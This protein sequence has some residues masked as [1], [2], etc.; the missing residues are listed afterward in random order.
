MAQLNNRFKRFWIEPD[1]LTGDLTDYPVVIDTRL[2]PDLKKYLS[3]SAAE[4]DFGVEPN[5]GGLPY[6]IEFDLKTNNLGR[7]MVIWVKLP[8]ISSTERTYFYMFYGNQSAVGNQ[9]LSQLWQTAYPFDAVYHG[10]VTPP[11]PNYALIDSSSN[12]RNALMNAGSCAPAPYTDAGIGDESGIFADL[13]WDLHASG[14]FM[15]D[16]KYTTGFTI[17]YWASF[18]PIGNMV[19]AYDAGASNYLTGIG[20]SAGIYHPIMIVGGGAPKVGTIALS[21]FTPYL[22]HFVKDDAAGQERI[23]VNGQLDST[24]AS[25]AIATTTLPTFSGNPCGA[26]GWFGT[27]DE[28]RFVD[29]V[30]P[31]D[32]IKADYEIQKTFM[33]DL[34]PS[35]IGIPGTVVKDEKEYKVKPK[36]RYPGIIS[37][38][39]ISRGYSSTQGRR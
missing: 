28:L 26:L 39:G 4:I 35:N 9:S 25:T 10:N 32:W 22:I 11:F 23:Y 13:A 8:F 18:V 24:H 3:T 12:G 7:R 6:E 30:L 36:G 1:L 29:T 20:P 33:W 31:A 38:K 16:P 37:G 15:T 27:F 2:D 21:A 19:G 14:D 5:S 34:G 17:S